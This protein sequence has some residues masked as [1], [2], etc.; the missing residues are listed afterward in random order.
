[1]ARPI[2]WFAGPSFVELKRRFAEAADDGVFE[3]HEEG[4][5]RYLYVLK[6]GEPSPE[7][8]SGGINESHICPPVCR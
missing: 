2:V 7:D 6:A 5:E 4:T 1:M 8:V 3:I